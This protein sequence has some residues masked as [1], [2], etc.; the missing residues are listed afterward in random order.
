MIYHHYFTMRIEDFTMIRL[1]LF[2]KNNDFLQ[3]LV[4]LDQEV[5]AVQRRCFQVK[6]QGLSF[7]EHQKSLKSVQYS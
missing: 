7:S 6:E 5:K 2:K 1:E 4:F 3:I